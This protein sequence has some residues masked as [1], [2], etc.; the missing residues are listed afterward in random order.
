MLHLVFSEREHLKS[1]INRLIKTITEKVSLAV[2]KMYRKKLPEDENDLNIKVNAIISANESEIRSEHPTVSFACAKVIPDHEILGTNLLIESKFIRKETSP[3]KAS[4][5]IAADL[6]TYPPS[7]HLLFLV[8]DP[9]HAI[10]DDAVF[11][12]DFESDGRCTIVIIR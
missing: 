12:T 2:P 5:G 3:S 7:C 9:T 11:K 4:A 10:H 1:S 8:F 6:T